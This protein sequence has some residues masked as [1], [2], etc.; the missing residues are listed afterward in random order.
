MKKKIVILISTI[1]VVIILLGTLWYLIACHG[2]SIGTWLDLTVNKE[3]NQY[4]IKVDKIHQGEGMPITPEDWKIKNFDAVICEDGV[5][6]WDVNLADILN[7]ETSNLTYYD[8]DGDGKVSVGDK[9]VVKG[10]LAE[11]GD[12]FRLYYDHH[13]YVIGSCTLE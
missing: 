11:S 8:V 4:L 3:D 12:R 7:N 10:V 6:M 1:T 13:A 2:G 5:W 9:F